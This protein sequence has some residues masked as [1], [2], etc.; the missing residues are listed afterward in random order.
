VLVGATDTIVHVSTDIFPS[1]R[2][3]HRRAPRRVGRW[4]L[5]I[6]VGAVVLAG[7]AIAVSLFAG[8]G[9]NRI[10]S[11]VV[12]VDYRHHDQVTVTFQVTKPPGVP[13]TCVVRARSYAGTE[14]GR[15][16]VPVP[17][18]HDGQRTVTVRYTL[19]TKSKPNTGEVQDC[20]LAR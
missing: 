20:T 10:T 18:G 4:L 14:I 15:T 8:Q 13:A 3:G 19:S 5:P 17:A 2:Y 12:G 9:G 16:R 6:L 11:E 7:L 1:G